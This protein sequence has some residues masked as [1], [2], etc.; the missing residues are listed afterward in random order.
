MR[1]VALLAAVVLSAV[2]ANPSSSVAATDEE[3]Y[4][5]NKNTHLFIK[6]LWNPYAAS[7]TPAAA[8]KAAKKK[9]AKAA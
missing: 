9:K 2:F 8:S 3:L 4:N 5:L 7:A 1:K 6:D